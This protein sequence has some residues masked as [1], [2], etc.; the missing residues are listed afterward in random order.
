MRKMLLTSV[1]ALGL[2]FAAPALAQNT[3]AAPGMGNATGPNET[4]T[5][6]PAPTGQQQAIPS[7]HRLMREGAMNPNTGARYGHVPGEGQS[8]PMSGHASNI[9]SNDTRSVIAPSLP[10]PPVGQNASAEQYLNV[11]QQALAR[12][13]TGEAQEALERAETAVLNRRAERMQNPTEHAP[14]IEDIRAALDAMARHDYASAQQSI[15][16][17][18]YNRATASNM[19]PEGNMPYEGTGMPPNQTSGMYQGGTPSGSPYRT[20]QPGTLGTEVSPPGT[21]MNPTG[22]P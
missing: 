22:Q 9:T 7:P 3:G 2:A 18:M 14:R 1:A 5:T 19:S 21:Q 13:R 17:A 20:A 12:H 16:T 8:L 10:V 4:M 15:S 11:A 6:P